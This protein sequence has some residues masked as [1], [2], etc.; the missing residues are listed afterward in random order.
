[1]ARKLNLLG[2]RFGKLVTVKEDYH[3]SKS[4]RKSAGYLCKCDCG[5]SEVFSA[6]TLARGSATTCKLC[7]G[8]S[9]KTPNS[10]R[11]SNKRMYGIWADMVKRCRNKDNIYYGGKG[12]EV[13]DRWEV[14]KGGSFE[15]FYNDMSESYFEEASIDRVDGEK[16]YTPSNCRWVSLDQQKGN[17]KPYKGGKYKGVRK[18]G[19]RYRSEIFHEGTSYLLAVVSSAESAAYIFNVVASILKDDTYYFNTIEPCQ[20]IS[21]TCS[22]YFHEITDNK[23]FDG[24]SY[25]PMSLNSSSLISESVTRTG[26][27]VYYP[28]RSSVRKDGLDLRA[29]CRCINDNSKTHKGYRFYN[30]L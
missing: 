1:M 3:K 15:N 28:S 5:G 23:Y 26:C 21:N 13:C 17:R 11:Q 25:C 24:G 16:S 18:S 7:R 30:V 22:Q 6:S 4:G 10:L 29:V 27:G 9:R 20:I 8:E 19:R 14:R 2:K 12:V